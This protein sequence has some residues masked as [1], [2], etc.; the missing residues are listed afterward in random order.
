MKDAM[1][2][3]YLVSYDAYKKAMKDAL[4]S[5]TIK[6]FVYYMNWNFGKGPR[7]LM[8]VG[9][10]SDDVIKAVEKVCNRPKASGKCIPCV[11]QNAKK[12]NVNYLKLQVK[13]GRVEVEKVERL[14][15]AARVDYAPVVVA[16]L[17]DFIVDDSLDLDS[18]EALEEVEKKEEENSELALV[19]KRRKERLD[20]AKEIGAQKIVSNKLKDPNTGKV[21]DAV[22]ALKVKGPG[23]LDEAKEIGAQSIVSKLKDPNSG[24][25]AD[26]NDIVADD[27]LILDSEL[28]LVMKRRKERLDEAKEIGA[29]TIVSKLKDPITGKVDDAVKALKAL[30]DARVEGLKWQKVEIQKVVD[31]HGMIAKFKAS[32]DKHKEET[33]K[34]IRDATTRRQELK[35]EIAYMRSDKQTK[36]K[37]LEIQIRMQ[38]KVLAALNPEIEKAEK[39]LVDLEEKFEGQKRRYAVDANKHGTGR[40]GA[41]TGFEQQA[42][43]AATGGMTADQQENV[44][45]TSGGDTAL[46]WQGLRVEW[47]NLVDKNGWRLGRRLKD[48]AAVKSRLNWCNTMTS[49]SFLGP[50]L[51]KEAVEMAAAIV[52]KITWDQ[53]RDGPDDEWMDL[54]RVLIQVG[55][56]KKNKTFKGWGISVSSMSETKLSISD[57]LDALSKFTDG[58]LTPDALLRK[59]EVAVDGEGKIQPHATVMFDRKGATWVNTSQYPAD[60]PVGWSLQGKLVRS[61]AAGGGGI[62]A[63][64]PWSV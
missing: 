55:P 60:A 26:L 37:T 52:N 7:P 18:E 59:L 56:P 33:E 10:I 23:H 49:S 31:A 3:D 16:D 30:M 41:H 35:D 28:A 24:K 5:T 27:S 61:K 14:F 57:A 50:E 17:N 53:V 58:E 48:E 51:E 13:S 11:S 39:E 64:G 2:L 4:R 12:E 43:R 9:S 6:P 34:R 36:K 44:W 54:T 47:E 62:K 38:E 63:G 8:L 32:Y 29:Q 1:Q 46:T 42:R 45:G 19:M 22:K 40:H 20:E 25:V 15:M 21:A